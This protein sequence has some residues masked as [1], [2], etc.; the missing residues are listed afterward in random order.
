M[1]A[2]I[3]RAEGGEGA[4]LHELAADTFGLACPPDTPAE[5]IVGFIAAQLSEERFEAYLAD[6]D[7]QILVATDG[8]R[9]LAYAMLITGEPTDPDVAAVVRAR[10]AV[11]LSKFYLRADS[12]GSGLAAQLMDSTLEHARLR[13]AVVVWLGVN[14]QNLRANRFYERS[15]F[16]IAG[17]KT[18]ALGDRLEEDFVRVVTL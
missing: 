2:S 3:R 18:F 15:G 6:P 5:A 9:F 8:G 17:T 11:E 10:P 16:G 12:H 1:T 7:R 13:G 4:M 14:Q